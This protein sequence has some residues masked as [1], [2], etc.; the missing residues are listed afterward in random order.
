MFH[1][2]TVCS[3]VTSCGSFEHDLW[4]DL[5]EG[6]FDILGD[7]S[8]KNPGSAYSEETIQTCNEIK[9]T[10]FGREYGVGKVA[11]I[12][13]LFNVERLGTLSLGSVYLECRLQK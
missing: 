8:T 5:I 10:L 7:P 1:K 6:N 13:L 9:K 3:K 2:H 4:H 12:N 11:F